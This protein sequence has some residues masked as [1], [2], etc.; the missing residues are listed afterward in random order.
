[1]VCSI[2]FMFVF[3]FVYSVFLYC[4]VYRFSFYT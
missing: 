3:H 4:F 1:M 2:H